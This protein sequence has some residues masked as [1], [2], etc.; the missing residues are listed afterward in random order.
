MRLVL[1]TQRFILSVRRY[2]LHSILNFIEVL[3]QILI[4]ITIVLWL[5]LI[6]NSNLKDFDVNKALNKTDISIFH[7]LEVQS[8]D[9]NFYRQIQGFTI[10]SLVMQTLKYLY[11]SKRM[12]KLL[13]VFHYALFD[14]IFSL[15]IFFIILIAFSVMAFFS[16]GVQLDEFN[17]FPK[18]LLNCCILLIGAV[19]LGKLLEVDVVMGTI[20]YF[21]FM[22]LKH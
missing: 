8:I 19:D 10:L 7:T 1:Y 9:F 12:S 18:S 22:V 3:T 14:F 21:S 17:T 11:F 20:F 13:D 5:S 4:F 16:F 15:A 6:S 2:L